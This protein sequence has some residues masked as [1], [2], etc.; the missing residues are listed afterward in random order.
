MQQRENK[1]YQYS[2]KMEKESGMKKR[3]SDSD[4]LEQLYKRYEQPMYR[5]AFSILHNPEQSE[6]VVADSFVKAAEQLHKFRNIESSQTRHFL[7]R[8]VKNIAI[9]TYRKNLK[10]YRMFADVDEEEVEDSNN[11]VM[12]HLLTIQQREVL[13]ELFRKLNPTYQEVLMLKCYYELS[14]SEI[15]VL[16]K[17]NEAAVRKRY[18]RAKKQVLAQ[19]GGNQNE[20]LLQIF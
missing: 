2:T 8:I 5:T 15:A 9:D 19:M 10:E 11:V 20:E 4:L 6:D 18:E 13:K 12:Q 3:I 7:L 1:M 16:L 17:V 14:Y